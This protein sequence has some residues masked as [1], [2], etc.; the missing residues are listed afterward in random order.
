MSIPPCCPLLPRYPRRGGRAGMGRKITGCTVHLVDEIMDHGEV[1]IQA[2][3][4]AI[5]GEPLDDLQS[6]IHAQEHRIY[7]QAL[8]WL[9][10]DRIK[11]DD[12]GRSCISCPAPASRVPLPACS[13]AR[14]LRKAFRG[15][16]ILVLRGEGLSSRKA[17]PRNLL[18]PLPRLSHA[19]SNRLGWRG[20]GRP[21]PSRRMGG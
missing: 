18:L 8:Q 20:P 11:M 7:P 5:A 19:G 12:D 16:K 4:P 2:A 10:E 21:K 1:I 15:R 17:S 9:A 13:S 6:R 14:R 3:M